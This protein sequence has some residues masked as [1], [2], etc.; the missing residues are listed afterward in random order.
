MKEG[1]FCPECGSTILVSRDNVPRPHWGVLECIGLER[2]RFG[3]VGAHWTL[4]RAEA[5]IVPF[6]KTHKGKLL[7]DCPRDYL[8]WIVATFEDG[9]GIK[10]AARILLEQ[11]ERDEP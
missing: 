8:E 10:T 6:G 11:P 3:W 1:D 7:K 9:R 5:F 4:E 2:H